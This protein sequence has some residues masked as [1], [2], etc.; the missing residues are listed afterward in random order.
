MN[1][2]ILYIKVTVFA[3][4]FQDSTE[5]IGSLPLQIDEPPTRFLLFFNILS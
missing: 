2:K 1:I 3:G 4:F 5:K